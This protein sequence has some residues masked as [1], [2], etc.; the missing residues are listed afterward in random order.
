LLSTGISPHSQIQNLANADQEKVGDY[1]SDT[2]VLY[3][4]LLLTQQFHLI[5]TSG[6]Q[7]LVLLLLLVQILLLILTLFHEVLMLVVVGFGLSQYHE[8]CPLDD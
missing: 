3:L 6:T 8:V 4:L 5:H 7:R 1:H 2:E